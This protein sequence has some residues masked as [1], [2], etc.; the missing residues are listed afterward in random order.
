MLLAW[1]I[2]QNTSKIWASPGSIMLP[3]E[4]TCW[5]LF[6]THS[7][8][9]FPGAMS[10]INQDSLFHTSQMARSAGEEHSASCIGFG[11]YWR[12]LFILSEF[13][14]RNPSRALILCFKL[15]YPYQVNFPFTK[16][17]N[18]KRKWEGI[19]NWES[20]STWSAHDTHYDGLFCSATCSFVTNEQSVWSLFTEVRPDDAKL[21]SFIR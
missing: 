12:L 18:I 5:K 15:V 9:Q 11:H 2:L 17:S 7:H 19:A 3:T 8:H 1:Q 13:A 10:N 4:C 6:S 14:V 20:Q 21:A 16:Q